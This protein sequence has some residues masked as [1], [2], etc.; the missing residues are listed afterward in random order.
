MSKFAN[1]ENGLDPVTFEV[2]KNSFI[3]TVDQMAEQM[4]RTC[5]SFVIYNRDFSNALHDADGNSVA[6]GNYD[7]AV[8]V[9]TLHNTCKEVIRVFEGDMAPGDVYA[10]NDPYAGGTHFSDVRLVR[11]IFDEDTLIGFAQSNGHWSDLGGS[12]PGSFDVTARDMFR[13]GL[14]ITP[15][16]LFRQGRFCSDVA[17]MIA[18]NTRDPA[19]IIGDIHSQAQATQAAEREL[20]RLTKKYGRDKV[21][22]GM[23]EVQDYVERAVRKR[24]ADLPD[25]TWETV[26]YIDR[27]LG[28]GEGMIPIRIKM[29]I[30]GDAVHYDFTGSH[31]T[32]ASMYNS[33]PGATFSAVVAGMK[34]FFPDLPL[35][36]GF[37][38]MIHV[39]APRNSVVSAEWPVAVTGFLMP[40]EKIM[41]AIF[42]MWSQIMPERAIACAFN[43]EYLLAGGRDAR[44]PEKPI[45]MFYEWLPGGWGGRNGKDGADVTTACF[46]TGLMSQP[47]EGNERVNPT[48]TTEFQIKRDSAGPGKWRGGVGVQKTSLLLEAEGAVMSYICDRER[49]V[50]WGVEGGL[51]SMPHGLTIRRAGAD[52]DTWLGSVFSDYPVFTGDEFAR[53][54]AGGG[55]FGDPLE[56][57]PAHVMED[58]IDDY[59]SIERAKL[60]Y[61]VVIRAIDADLCEYEI[62]V[63]ATQ[64]A[65]A[66]IRAHRKDWA[67]MNPH[68]VSARYKSGEINSLDAVRRFAVILDWES[69]EVL[70]KTTAQFRES[71]EKRSVAHWT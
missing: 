25:G 28:A 66:D 2:L 40:F 1:T 3:T 15:V 27:D 10:I 39:T 6:Q 37:Y 55:G 65:R 26:D 62:D 61:G 50:V 12:V 4:L 47:N 49:A 67:R 7:I 13:E 19:S 35:N 8:H 5:Y 29:T 31:A 41:N 9:G 59:V 21:T 53:P 23:G 71:F 64:A 63:A 43:L 32:I 33:A 60:D 11:P 54:T 17:N 51:P 58:V 36:S 48:R 52:A 16:R 22:R 68:A 38:R 44:K 57:D 56:R 18:A 14:R 69:G 20:L 34:T 30:K 45:F 42:E 70:E 24:L 46:G